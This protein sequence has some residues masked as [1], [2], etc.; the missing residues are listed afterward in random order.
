MNNVSII[1]LSAI[2]LATGASHASDNQLQTRKAQALKQA[3]AFADHPS[4][5]DQLDMN[6]SSVSKPAYSDQVLV[7]KFPQTTKPNIK[8]PLSQS[9]SIYLQRLKALKDIELNGRSVTQ[10]KNKAISQQQLSALLE[11]YKVKLQTPKPAKPKPHEP[12]VKA[13]K[14][15]K[16]NLLNMWQRLTTSQKERGND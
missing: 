1:T 13:S 4:L 10:H 8:M 11:K 6:D 2:F 16:K 14:E 12:S 3:K 7:D 9:K 5:S 15:Q